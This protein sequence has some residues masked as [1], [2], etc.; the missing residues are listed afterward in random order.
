MVNIKNSVD[1]L[2]AKKYSDI[3]SDDADTAKKQLREYCKLYH[4]DANDSKEA[5]ELFCIVQELYNNK[6]RIISSSSTVVDDIIIKNKATG[7]GFVLSNYISFN[8]GIAMIYHT[9]TKVA[10]IYDKSYKKFYEQYIK[11]VKNLQ[12]VN[13]D[14]RKEFERYFPKIINNFETEDDQFC[15]LLDKTS[16]V[17]SLGKIVRSYE[18]KKEEFP[19]RQAAWIL[20][21]LYNIA[22]Y[23]NFYKKVFNGFS[24]D[25]LWVS[26]EM[27]TILPF[28]GWEYSTDI[29]D[30]MIGCPKD[31]YK[32]LPIKVKDTKES[33]TVT[34]LESIKS[35]GR[36]LF[37]GKKLEYINKFLNSGTSDDIFTEWDNYRNAVKKQFGK[38]EFIIWEDVPY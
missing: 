15:I 2:K 11:N 9:A 20:N 6:H 16:D 26:P 17:L 22:C 7:K 25:N 37:K 30:S 29:G 33:Q 19:E 38:S 14:M 4:P 31:V 28:S 8:N 13:S 3:F 18:T 23:M 34:D 24:L 32:I 1:I 5:A 27:H 35:I 10:M 21:R 12:Y 36:I